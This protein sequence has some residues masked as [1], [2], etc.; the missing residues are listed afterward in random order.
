MSAEDPD[1]ERLRKKWWLGRVGWGVL[2]LIQLLI[3]A[4]CSTIAWVTHG[5]SW[6]AWVVASVSLPMLVMRRVLPP[7]ILAA[8]SKVLLATTLALTLAGWLV[9]TKFT[10]FLGTTVFVTLGAFSLGFAIWLSML[11]I[12]GVGAAASRVAISPPLDG[13]VLADAMRR[14]PVLLSLVMVMLVTAGVIHAAS[15]LPLLSEAVMDSSSG[16]D[17]VAAMAFFWIGGGIGGFSRLARFEGEKLR[18]MLL[19]AALWSSVAVVAALSHWPLFLIGLPALILGYTW[20]R[21]LREASEILRAG[22]QR[23]LRRRVPVWLLT[24]MGAGAMLAGLLAFSL[25]RWT[26]PGTWGAWLRGAL[27]AVL[28]LIVASVLA[29]RLRCEA[30][31]SATRSGAG[32]RWFDFPGLELA[33]YE[34]PLADATVIEIAYDVPEQNLPDFLEAMTGMEA[35][36]QEEGAA[37]WTLTRDS[38]HPTV[39]HEFFRVESWTEYQLALNEESEP[40][41]LLKQ[42]AFAA[43]DWETL[44]AEIHYPV[45]HSYQVPEN[46]AEALSKPAEA[47]GFPPSESAGEATQSETGNDPEAE[48]LEDL[49][50]ADGAGKNDETSEGTS[51]T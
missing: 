51:G 7:S 46:D 35:V 2:L 37:W 19:V 44:P 11:G 10:D 28:M 22:L 45:V 39:F 42:K 30:R 41:R 23:S 6:I 17:S 25:M 9:F 13:R 31:D 8:N 49:A 50:D 14:A 4:N 18:S 34:S 1:Q 33:P 21:T 43:N 40:A 24:W 27:P 16:R 20:A 38:S 15:V 12:Q 32:R 47:D 29:W 5:F 3:Y 36:R 26:D 48:F